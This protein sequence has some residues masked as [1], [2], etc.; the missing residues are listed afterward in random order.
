MKTIGLLLAITGI[1][2][3]CFCPQIISPS[4]G[5]GGGAS[6][7]PYYGSAGYATPNYNYN[8]NSY[9]A[10]QPAGAGSYAIFYRDLTPFRQPYYQPQQSYPQR[11]PPPPVYPQPIPPPI[12]PQPPRF[13]QQPV[14]VQPTVAP[15]RVTPAR[16]EPPTTTQSPVIVHEG[17]VEY[18]QED[19]DT[20]VT[21]TYRPVPVTTQTFAPIVEIITTTT[22]STTQLPTTTQITPVPAAVQDEIEDFEDT[23]EPSKKKDEFY[24]VYYDEKGN[25]VGDSRSGTTFPPQDIIQ[26]VTT[27]AAIQASTV[28][29]LNVATGK[30][31]STENYDD[32]VVEQTAKVGGKTGDVVYEDETIE[33]EDGTTVKP[34]TIKTLKRGLGDNQIMVS[35]SDTVGESMGYRK[36]LNANGVKIV[37]KQRADK[38]KLH[39]N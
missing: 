15:I 6:Y 34:T 24:Y 27:V 12:R 39:S 14:I 17:Q 31:E 13:P 20:T 36:R 4:C 21:T 5:C 23:T 29:A 8:Y 16:Y 35:A 22:T 33:Y 18:E 3:S 37:Q 26:E 7:T 9:A 28:K 25:K 2:S 38:R 1:A 10:P 11:I 32:I 30:L 19:Y